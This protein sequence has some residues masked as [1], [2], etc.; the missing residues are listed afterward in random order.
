G[1]LGR[2]VWLILAS[3]LSAVTFQT[4]KQGRIAPQLA[5]ETAAALA[6]AGLYALLYITGRQIGLRWGT[7][8]KRSWMGARLEAAGLFASI[9]CAILMAQA[10][11]Q[12]GITGLTMT[13]GLMAL[14]LLIAH[15]G[16]EVAL[17]R[18][19]VR[20]M[21]KI[22]AMTLSQANPSRVV[23][24]FLH[25]SS[26]LIPC[27]RISLWLTDAS[28]TRLERV[29]RRQSI[30][31]QA[32]E[33]AGMADGSEVTSLRFGEGLVGRVADRQKHQILRAGASERYAT[34]LLPL[35]A[36]GE[37]VGVAQFEREAP[38]SYTP[39]DMARVRSIVGQVAATIANMRMHRD[40]YNQAV[41]D[42]LTGL[43][44]RRHMQT[45]L[46]E[47]RLRAARYGH[48]LS[49]IMLD[50]DGFKNYNDTYGH[51]QGDVL[52]TMLAN[53]LRENVR[54]VDI[55][56]RYGGEEFIIVLPETPKQEAWL[57]AERLRS[58]VA[59][60]I[61]P[62]FPD[63]PEM[64]VL[65]TIS[66]GLATFPQD[67][68]DIQTLVSMADQALYRAK[69]GGRNQVVSGGPTLAISTED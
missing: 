35:V 12:A 46:L 62:G 10:W 40:I 29:A 13:T 26:G 7:L 60:T 47:E 61:F 32:S 3:L 65:K 42:G 53:Q 19:Q 55:V 34:L 16:F 23:E 41:T 30:A 24:R 37:T 33:R 44:N 45:V 52:L 64:V 2:G 69:R 1:V 63:D 21:E 54:E 25:L 56:G 58:A 18:E 59:A 66:L 51:P 31:A 36:S 15:F 50:V 68:D 14:L 49:V 38:G 6:A 9:P 27:D 4:L 22:S 5:S 20:A 48:P 43:Y 28:Q 67:T 39:R 11:A 8:W 57:T 17:L